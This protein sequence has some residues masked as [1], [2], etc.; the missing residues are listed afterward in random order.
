MDTKRGDGRT[1]KKLTKTAMVTKL[2]QQNESLREELKK[3]SE[4]VTKQL[5]RVQRR[6]E[7]TSEEHI[8][9][10][11]DHELKNAKKQAELNQKELAK[12]KKFAEFCKPEKITELEKQ[13]A[14]VDA[15]ISQLNLDKKTLG[16]KQ[17]E[18]K[19]QFAQAEQSGNRVKVME[20]ELSSLK[21]RVRDSEDRLGREKK[22][23]E[24]VQRHHDDLVHR[25]EDNEEKCKS[26]GIDLT[27]NEAEVEKTQHEYEVQRKKT[28]VLK[29][30]MKVDEVT[31]K[32][33]LKEREQK[34]EEVKKQAEELQARIDEREEEVKKSTALIIDLKEQVKNGQGK[35]DANFKSSVH[36]V[37]GRDDHR[38]S[39]AGNGRVSTTNEYYDELSANKDK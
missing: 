9:K 35:S 29:K 26:Q 1:E 10:A 17:R 20:E 12:W 25:K 7:G 11:R 31:Y 37:G 15:E 24:N 39:S 5:E 6:T 27:I 21:G 4:Q 19:K 23:L 34:L 18:Q 14:E 30:A 32:A 33:K 2:K 36:G 16:T 3:I 13:I 38:R 8:L 22:Q 28:L